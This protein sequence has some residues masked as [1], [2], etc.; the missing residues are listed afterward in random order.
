VIVLQLKTVLSLVACVFERE[1]KC[2]G[3]L[4][5][6][7]AGNTLNTQCIPLSYVCDGKSDCQDG[8]DERTCRADRMLNT[9]V[10]NKF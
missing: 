8:S 7:V 10:K 4:G 3:G 2:V 5:V 9:F 1:M 6:G